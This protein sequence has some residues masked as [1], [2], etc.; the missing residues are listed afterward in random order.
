[1]DRFSFIYGLVLILWIVVKLPIYLSNYN[2]DLQRV[3]E[4][5]IQCQVNNAADAAVE[6]ML[7]SSDLEQDYNE[8]AILVDPDLGLREFTTVLGT[9]LGY[10]ISDKTLAEIPPKYLKAFLVCGWDGVYSYALR[11]SE[12]IGSEFISTPKIPYYYTAN[13]GTPA[14][15]QYV[16]NLGL[17]KGYRDGFHNGSYKMFSYD[18]ITLSE[19]EQLLAINNE[20]SQLLVAALKE[21]NL[22]DVP[23][24]YSLSAYASEIN[25]SQPVDKITVIAIVDTGDIA[26]MGVGG[27]YIDVRD[28]IVGFIYNGIKYYAKQSA[29]EASPYAAANVTREFESIFEAA[30]EGYHCKIDLFE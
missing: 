20:V 5:E 24:Y 11:H 6:A 9:Q 17:T 23:A 22:G 8:D 21:S 29:L 28:P 10:S 1:M 26:T 13:A 7:G 4:F 18:D 25:G 16:L 27:S 15:T 3:R 14:Q 30:D 12:S 2:D 19:T